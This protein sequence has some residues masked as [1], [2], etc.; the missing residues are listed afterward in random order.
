[1]T[2]SGGLLIS[3]FLHFLILFFIL[4]GFSKTAIQK[5]VKL[6]EPILVAVTLLEKSPTDSIID[7]G[8]G[9][10]ISSE[11]DKLI[12]ANADKEYLGIGILHGLRGIDMII[13]APMY[14]P[15]YRAGIREGDKI[16]SLE[17]LGD[18]IYITILRN[19]E[20]LSFKVKMEKICFR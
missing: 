20:N 9:I 16:I 6:E 1:M 19:E 12:C 13:H 14:Y 17:R 10:G 3:L 15:A 8:D 4:Y 18:F 7:T 5:E 11:S 2:K